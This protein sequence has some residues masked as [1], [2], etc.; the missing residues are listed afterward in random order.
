M[1]G[2]WQYRSRAR[3][4]RN[5]SPN[6]ESDPHVRYGQRPGASFLFPDSISLWYPPLFGDNQPQT[7]ALSALS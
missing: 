6:D 1:A 5:H 2:S 4:G 3:G 7:G